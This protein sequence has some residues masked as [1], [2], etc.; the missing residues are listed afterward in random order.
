VVLLV[1][2][3]NNY[4]YHLH[5]CS[6]GY[7]IG[8]GPCLQV[9]PFYK[10]CFIMDTVNPNRVVSWAET[11]WKEHKRAEEALVDE[12]KNRL[13]EIQREIRALENERDALE[14]LLETKS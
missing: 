3:S 2:L 10:Y 12:T 4:Y 8:A 9:G 6:D 7:Y 5:P 13:K 1:R 14:R 11:A